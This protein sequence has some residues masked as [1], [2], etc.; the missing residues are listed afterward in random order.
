MR[1]SLAIL[2]VV[3]LAGCEPP[4]VM[5]DA[6]MVAKCDPVAPNLLKNAGF[7]CTVTPDGGGAVPD[8]W[9]G[10]YGQ[11]AVAVG[12]GRNGGNAGKGTFSGVG[13]RFAYSGDVV[14][15]GG[16][17]VFCASAWVKGTAPYMRMNL[18][19][20]DL[21]QS[22]A[23]PVTATWEK[24]PPTIKLNIDNASSKHLQLMFEAQTGRT[25]GANAKAGD[26]LL[27]DDAEV[28]ESPSGMCTE[29]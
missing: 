6:G 8:A 29:H 24:V 16:T 20:D 15:N 23:A 19:R 26:T 22:F 27:V 12:E 11:F 28:W 14:S 25:D 5:M 2:V 18:I 1:A 9:Q 13:L 7:E 21:V 17:K 3:L 10:V 4:V